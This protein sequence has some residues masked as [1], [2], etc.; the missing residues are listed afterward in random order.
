MDSYHTS[1]ELPG[2]GPTHHG[3]DYDEHNHKRYIRN[4]KQREATKIK[5]MRKKVEDM[6]GKWTGHVA[7]MQDDKWTK[8]ITERRERLISSPNKDGEAK[9]RRNVAAFK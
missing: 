2:S 6:R 7:R 5:D 9:S 4:E 3:K 1:R 8:R